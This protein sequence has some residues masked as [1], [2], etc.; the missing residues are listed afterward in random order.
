MSAE[1]VASGG[2]RK[3]A[4][5]LLLAGLGVAALVF[6]RSWPRDTE[7]AVRIGG[8]RPM[9]RRVELSVRR[10]SDGEEEKGVSWSFS[11]GKVPPVVRTTL[12][13]SPTEYDV[14]LSA[15]RADGVIQR[16]TKRV[17]LSGEVVNLQLT[18]GE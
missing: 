12:H 13:F 14:F 11:Q 1:P 3:W 16:E 6:S 2:R 5:G 17:T 15:E 4:R 10:P 8:D 7:V 18:V 9:L